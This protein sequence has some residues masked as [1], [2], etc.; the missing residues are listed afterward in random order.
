MKRPSEILS[1][2]ER[3]QLTEKSDLWAWWLVLSSWA[4]VFG[5]LAIAGFYP[6][7]FTIVLVLLVLPGRQLSLSV[8]MHE[9][10]HNTLFKTERLNR[11]VGQWL[12]ALPTFGDLKSYA[13]GHLEHHRKAGTHEDPDLP[14]YAAY[15]ISRRSFRRKV[16]RD[17]TGQTGFKLLAGIF[18]GASG[19]VGEGQR[20]GPSIL[21]KQ[22]G[23]QLALFAV[24]S[25][26]GIGWT[27]LLWFATFV[28][29]HMF[30]IRFRQV[31]EHAAVP[32]LYDLDPRLN[33]RTVDAP[34]W[35]RFLIAP[36]FVNFHMEHHFMAGVPCYRLPRLRALL[37]ER[38]F[39]DQV[40]DFSSYGQVLRSA[41]RSAA[42]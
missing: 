2:E 5:L 18:A 32:D 35:Q 19:I 13:D 33:T 31:A 12:C 34:G 36:N 9:A 16:I 22:V 21:I 10:G 40:E 1:R 27:W 17:L 37:R 8:L 7:I 30:V 25:L 29:T 39:L 11:W 28:T 4:L 24:L 3:Q 20:S 42:A 41:L 26:M 23:V 14:N 38:G 6:S 15:P